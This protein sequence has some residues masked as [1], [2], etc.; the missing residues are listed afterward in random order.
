MIMSNDRFPVSR[1]EFNSP[2]VDYSNICMCT[3][4]SVPAAVGSSVLKMMSHVFP[5][6][7][8]DEQQLKTRHTDTSCLYTAIMN[9]TK[10]DPDKERSI[11]QY[12]IVMPTSLLKLVI[13][14]V[15]IDM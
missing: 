10:H 7:R 4:L 1:I 14:F 11:F 8:E 3:L 15:L 13:F 5:I 6:A 12:A 2:Y 9:N